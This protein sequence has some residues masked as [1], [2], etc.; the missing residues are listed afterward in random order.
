M[1]LHK[2]LRNLDK[3]KY[4]VIDL[5][6]KPK[7]RNVKAVEK[8]SESY[9]GMLTPK[10]AEEFYSPK[11]TSLAYDYELGKMVFRTQNLWSKPQTFISG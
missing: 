5:T 3:E 4:E 2:M 8:E 7:I 10:D 11:V 1:S 9:T 6:Y